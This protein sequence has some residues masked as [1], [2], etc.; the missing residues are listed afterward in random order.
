VATAPPLR[1]SCSHAPTRISPRITNVP[2]CARYASVMLPGR[3]SSRCA[4][5][6]T[7]CPD[8]GNRVD[9]HSR[10]IRLLLVVDQSGRGAVDQLTRAQLLGEAV[11]CL[12]AKTRLSSSTG[13]ST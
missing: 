7:A 11:C 3:A 10:D 1:V 12:S 13:R 8:L 4:A 2:L 9:S 6:V 5:E